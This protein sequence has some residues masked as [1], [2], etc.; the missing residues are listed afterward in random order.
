MLFLPTKKSSLLFLKTKKIYSFLYSYFIPTW[1]KH[2]RDTLAKMMEIIHSMK[3]LKQMDRTRGILENC[4]LKI[5]WSCLLGM[6][7]QFGWP[8]H[9][10]IPT[11]GYLKVNIINSLEQSTRTAAPKTEEK[12]LIKWHKQQWQGNGQI[13][14][15]P[16]HIY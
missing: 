3:A 10:S 5:L 4:N 13:S 8:P 2:I 1:T 11:E 15:Q 14:L 16:V 12:S 7:F 6:P 9:W